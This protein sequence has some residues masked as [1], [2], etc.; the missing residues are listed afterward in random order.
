MRSVDFSF[1]SAWREMVREMERMGMDLE[2]FPCRMPVAGRYFYPFG[3]EKRPRRQARNIF[4]H[5]IQNFPDEIILVIE[6]HDCKRESIEVSLVGSD[7]VEI[8]CTRRNSHEVEIDSH[9]LRGLWSDTFQ[10]IFPL[11]EEV[12]MKGAKSTYRNGVLEVRL[13]KRKGSQNTIRID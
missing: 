7:S 2:P 6:V 10:H 9:R 12:T 4:R 1:V 5:E 11:P 3:N 8:S 13:K